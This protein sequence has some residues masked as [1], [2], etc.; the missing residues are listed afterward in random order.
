MEPTECL[1]TKPFWLG[2]IDTVEKKQLLYILICIFNEYKEISNIFCSFVL[3]KQS[4]I[5]DL[6]Y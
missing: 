3:R 5:W 6:K 2:I 1:F 4:A